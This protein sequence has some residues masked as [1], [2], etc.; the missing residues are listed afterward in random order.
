MNWEDKIKQD[1]KIFVKMLFWIYI[2]LAP[3]V[4]GNLIWWWLNDNLTDFG[5]FSATSYAVGLLII[6]TLKTFWADK[7]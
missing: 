3:I 5:I 6:R 1:L 2:F 7:D 4:F